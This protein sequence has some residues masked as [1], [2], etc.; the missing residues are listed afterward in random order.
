MSEIF[1]VIKSKIF[2]ELG[3]P[4]SRIAQVQISQDEFPIDV[5]IDRYLEAFLGL[6]PNS[7]S[8]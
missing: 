1:S 4:P 6:A 5:K 8:Y 2:F 7:K 3:T